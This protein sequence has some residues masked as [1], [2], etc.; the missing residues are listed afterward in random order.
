[1]E[2]VHKVK[3]DDI[4]CQLHPIPMRTKM[5]LDGKVLRFISPAAKALFSQAHDRTIDQEMMG[6]IIQGISESF[7]ALNAVEFDS[8]MSELLSSVIAT[9]PGK[10]P[11]QLS[12]K[13]FDTALHGYSSMTV[14]KIIF[15]VMRYNKFLPFE[16]GGLVQSI[17]SLTPQTAG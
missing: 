4:E 12:G 3:V 9:I 6:L 14:Y 16:L 17:G 7:A 13:D 8:M 11:V 5:A 10:A 1:M 2:L 15:E